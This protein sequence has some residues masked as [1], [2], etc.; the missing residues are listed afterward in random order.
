VQSAIEGRGGPHWIPSLLLLCVLIVPG[1]LALLFWRKRVM[2]VTYTR[3][4]PG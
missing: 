3:T 1:L 4:L 2:I